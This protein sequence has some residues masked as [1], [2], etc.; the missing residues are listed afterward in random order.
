MSVS[1]FLMN[2]SV[3][4]MFPVFLGLLCFLLAHMTFY[5]FSYSSL[6]FSITLIYT[7]AFCMQFRKETRA[8]ILYFKSQFY[9]NFM[10]GGFAPFNTRGWSNIVTDDK[11]NI[12]ESG[13]DSDEE[14]SE[15]DNDDFDP[16]DNMISRRRKRVRNNDDVV[17]VEKSD[18]PIESIVDDDSNIVTD[19]NKSKDV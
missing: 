2:T 19:N 9:K 14:L 1:S 18:E 13:N 17:L 5:L 4:T 3:N 15:N 8:V 11:G 6:L 7:A 16:T 10:K 12:V